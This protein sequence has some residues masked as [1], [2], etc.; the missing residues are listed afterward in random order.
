MMRGQIVKGIAGF[1]FVKSGETIYR[2]KARGLFKK[3]GMKP[4]V[5]DRVEFDEASGEDDGLITGILPRK[6]SFV[7]PFV[8]NVDRF[9]VVTAAARPAP[10]LQVIDKMLVAAEQASTEPII[11]I[12]K[13]DLAQEDKGGKAE[14]A[15]ATIAQ[16]KQIYEGVY[17]VVCTSKEDEDSLEEIRKLIR[18]KTVALAGASGTGKSTILNRLL[19]EEHMET[20]GISEKSLRGRHTTRHVQL[21]DL[22]DEG[23]MIFDTPGFTSFDLPEIDEAELASLFPEIDEMSEGCRY[24]DCMH[25]AE[26]DCAV[27]EGLEAGKI[28]PS[29]YESYRAFMEEVR[30]QKEY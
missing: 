21:F 25:M 14:K 15:K 26:P 13:C 1:Y 6:N 23:T 2:C 27:K 7:R 28:A 9:V 3:Q 10:V 30:S 4:A 29:R 11:C 16:I 24:D 18:G 12:N 22:D 19:D 17:P 20:G 5:G 8:S